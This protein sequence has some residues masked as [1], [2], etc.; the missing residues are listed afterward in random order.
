M[1]KPGFESSHCNATSSGNKRHFSASFFS[2]V[3]EWT[4]ALSAQSGLH[5]SWCREATAC[6]RY[7]RKMQRS[8]GRCEDS[9]RKTVQCLFRRPDN[10]FGASFL[11]T[12][13]QK[14]KGRLHQCG[15]RV[16]PGLFVGYASFVGSLDQR[17]ADRG[18]AS[19]ST[20]KGSKGKKSK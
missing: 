8:V 17:S 18:R 10:T 1:S 14:D 3:K 13:F 11:C 15:P 6:R 12:P 4:S 20:L 2:R 19:R 9:S 7:L 16:F 5:E